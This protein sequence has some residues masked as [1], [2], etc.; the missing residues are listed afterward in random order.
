MKG[1]RGNPVVN[2]PVHRS[3]E[4]VFAVVVH[5]EHK[6]AVDHDAERMKA[7]GDGLVI[8]AQVLPLVAAFQVLRRQRFEADENAAQPGLRSA[9][10]QV[11]AQNGIHR[12]RALKHTPHA[13]H[14]LKQRF[15]KTPVAQQMIVEKVE[16]APRQALNLLERIVQT[17][18]VKPASALK[19]CILVAEVAML[20]TAARD[21]DGVWNQVAIAPYQIAANGRNAFQCAA[22]GR[23]VNAFLLAHAK[24][25]QKLREGLFSGAQENCIGVS[26]SL[27][28]ERGY[29]QP[30]QANEGSFRAVVVRNPV[31]AMGIRNV[32]LNHHQVGNIVEREPFYML[33]H[34]E[35][36][37]VP[38]E[39]RCQ[40]SKA[41]RR[42]Q[43]VFDRTPIGAG[44]LSQRGE[45]ELGINGA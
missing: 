6:A 4:H 30:T 45:N 10:N 16:M 38:R 28:R 25:F 42:K 13:F 15:R 9:L 18:R 3:L 43:R 12:G 1:G 19:E 32:D 34:N 36:T 31:S 5:A 23:R 33:V 17:L 24:V 21:H 37:I 14:A 11:A 40:R 8:P 39:I 20:R 29:M 26:G 35:P 2:G 22:R 41:Q 7:I 44:G 27:F